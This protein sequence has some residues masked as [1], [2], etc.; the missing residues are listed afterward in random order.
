MTFSLTRRSQ[1]IRN[2][3]VIRKMDGVSDYEASGKV[4]IEYVKTE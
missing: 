3:T 1:D 2:K 4:L